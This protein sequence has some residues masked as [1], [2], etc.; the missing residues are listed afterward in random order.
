MMLLPG[1]MGQDVCLSKYFD[2]CSEADEKNIGGFL[3]LLFCK[4]WNN[5]CLALKGHAG[6]VENRLK[7]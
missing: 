3:L 1:G 5:L 7:G 2:F 4:D 6:C